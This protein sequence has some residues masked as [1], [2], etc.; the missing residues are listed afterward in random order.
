VRFKVSLF[1]I[2]LVLIFVLPACDHVRWGGVEVGVRPPETLVAE[3]PEP[4]LTPDVPR[5]EPIVSGPLVYL[6]ERSGT[7]ALLLPVAEWRGGTYAPLPTPDETPEWVQRFPL[8]RWDEGT[9]FLLLDR[10][11]RAGT[12]IADGSASWQEDRCQRR[13]AGWGSVELRPEAAGVRRF[14]ALRAGDLGEM[15]GALPL[16]PAPWPSAP[17]A[18]D[19][20]TGSL[21][22]ARVVLSRA[23]IPW[24]P[25]IPDITRARSGVVPVEGVPGIAASFVF[26][27]ELNV[28]SGLPGGYSLFALAERDPGSQSGWTPLWT[29][30]QTHR[31]GKAA[32]ELMA[33]GPLPVRA[34]GADP[35][36]IPSDFI[37]EVF[38]A[39]ERSLAILGRRSDGWGL[40]YQDA[41]G[42]SPASGAT[43]SWR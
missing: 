10:G 38:G 25:S 1:R 33:G 8:G 32:A 14:L 28:G 23:S 11:V 6:V 19:L 29:W 42:T 36:V 43:R 4:E 22:V 3:E 7:G 2:S 18:T 26:G 30:Y 17:Q 9:E 34:A 40:R 37:L 31:Q 16:A 21:S 13:P 27:G 15:G 24:P 35:S 39:E 12:F 41:C 20:L 5:L